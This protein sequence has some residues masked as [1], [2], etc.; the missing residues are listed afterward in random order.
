[1]NSDREKIIGLLGDT[2]LGKSL[3]ELSEIYDRIEEE[4]E[5]F[6][7]TFNIHCKS[8][9]GTCCEHFIPDITS[10][11][12]KMVASY[13]LLIKRDIALIDKVNKPSDGICPLYNKDNPYHCQV[14]AARP[15][16]CRLF[17]QCPS[18]MKDGSASFRRCK[19]EGGS[20]M[21]EKL[22]F[23]SSETVKTMDDYGIQVRSIDN[24]V[25][26]LDKAVSK[27]ISEVAL[28]ASLL[29]ILGSSSGGDSNPTPTPTPAPKAS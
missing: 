17:A 5:E 26:D 15:L 11:E 23:P 7:S 29:G 21:P 16:I 6:C 9:C 8:G 27:A 14:Y 20:R 19:F 25:E 10:V 12:A 3:S 1:M 2:S 13:I 28:L 18:R 24:T 22:D 4:T